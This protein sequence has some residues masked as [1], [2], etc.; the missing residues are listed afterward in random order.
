MATIYPS[1]K[2][3]TFRLKQRW[4]FLLAVV[5]LC[6]VLLAGQIP[7]QKG[8]GIESS[9]SYNYLEDLK[10]H[11]Q[12][13]YTINKHEPFAGIEFPINSNPISNYGFNLGYRFFPNQNQQTFD[14]Y[15]LY[16]MEGTSRKLYSNSTVN[17]FSLHNLLGYG[18]NVCLSDVFLLKHFI[19][20]GIENS[21]F[22]ED[23][24]FSDLSLMIG[25]GIGIKIKKTKADQ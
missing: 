14:F 1:V 7:R 15:F 23:G 16:L 13:F 9:I 2:N 4:S 21:W 20:G 24:N 3:R 18:F 17:G 19:A 10:I 5:L 25:L 6:P 11:F 8:Y 12:G 22:G